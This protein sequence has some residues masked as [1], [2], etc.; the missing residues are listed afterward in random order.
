MRGRLAHFGGA[1]R[2]EDKHGDPES[3]AGRLKG[4]KNGGARDVGEAAPRIFCDD[5]HVSSG[6]RH[7][8]DEGGGER[9]QALRGER[10][11]SEAPLFATESK[12]GRHVRKEL[13]P[14]W[15]PSERR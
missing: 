12:G 6:S 13:R 5:G 3:C 2:I 1:S 11:V 9:N 10:Q 14:E 4:P 15:A 8:C 7:R